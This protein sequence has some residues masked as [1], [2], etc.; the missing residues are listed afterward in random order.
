MAKCTYDDGLEL[1]PAEITGGKNY[2]GVS[3]DT[4]PT[5][6]PL[7]SLY[8]ELDTGTFYYYSG[9]EWLEVGANA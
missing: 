9:S 7:Y 8:L 4:K 2:R 6:V 3:T 5:H 1:R